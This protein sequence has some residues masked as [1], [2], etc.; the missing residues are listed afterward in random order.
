M[1]KLFTFIDSNGIE[2]C[3]RWTDDSIPI[4]VNMQGI[5][6]QLIPANAVG[7]FNDTQLLEHDK[8]WQVQALQVDGTTPFS[9][10]GID[11]KFYAK[12]FPNDVNLFFSK[13][14]SLN[15]TDV[16]VPTPT[17]GII[18]V[19]VRAADIATLAVGV[20]I[21]LYVDAIDATSGNPWN[22]AKWTLTTDN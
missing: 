18:Q 19:F 22:V 6:P 21:F 1:S 9:L 8:G 10:V 5:I 12:L 2:Q 14:L 3:V 16:L 15:P 20:T 11:V 7:L 17:N 4:F 13:S